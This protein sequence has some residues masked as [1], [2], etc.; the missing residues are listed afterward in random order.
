MPRPQEQSLEPR[1]QTSSYWLAQIQRQG[2]VAFGS[3]PNYKVFRS[4]KDYGA[5]G[6]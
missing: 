1:Q 6:M 5:V 3:D 4:V 2:T